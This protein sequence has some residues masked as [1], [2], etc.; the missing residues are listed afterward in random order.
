MAVGDSLNLVYNVADSRP[1]LITTAGRS[2]GRGSLTNTFHQLTHPLPGDRYRGHHRH[3]EELLQPTQI[4]MYSSMLGIVP[5]IQGYYYRDF[6]LQQLQGQVEIPLQI[7]SINHIDDNIPGGKHLGGYFFSFTGWLQGIGA[8]DIN[9]LHR[10]FPQ[11]HETTGIAHCSPGI[12][13]GNHMDTGET[14]KEGA[15]P[16]VGVTHQQYLH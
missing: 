7:G 9:N 16:H 5:Y 10:L 6:P 1:A 8:R 14:R 3:P 12:I 4:D 15:F 11:L 13:G 2:R